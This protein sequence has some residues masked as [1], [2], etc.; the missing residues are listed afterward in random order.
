M[1]KIATFLLSIF[2]AVTF[3]PAGHAIVAAC[4]NEFLFDR[5]MAV[6]RKH[7]DEIFGSGSARKR[8]SVNE[9]VRQRTPFSDYDF[10]P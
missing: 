1:T 9:S 5:R 6:S 7:R 3:D 4:P 2:G 10:R 8:W